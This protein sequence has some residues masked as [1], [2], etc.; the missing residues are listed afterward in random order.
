VGAEMHL[1]PQWTLL[2]KLDG[3]FA[4]RA[5]IHAGT[6]TLRYTW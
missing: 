1:T 2:G 4:S 3:E 6:G 5:Q